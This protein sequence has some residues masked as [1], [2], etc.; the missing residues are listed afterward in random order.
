MTLIDIKHAKYLEECIPLD[1]IK[2]LRKDFRAYKQ[3]GNLPETFGRDAPYDF[4]PLRRY[5]ELRHIHVRKEKPYPVRLLQYRRTADRVLIYC[6]GY[7]NPNAYLLIAFIKHWNEKTP[8]LVEGTDKD[9]IIM[10][11]VERLAEGFR[12]RY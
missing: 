2:A 6:S 9:P 3:G 12:E 7:T 11:T 4:T 10:A 1:Q 8:E 5:L